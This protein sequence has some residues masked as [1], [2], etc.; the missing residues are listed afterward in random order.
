[1]PALSPVRLG[2]IE[3]RIEARVS[4]L[5]DQIL[6]N[7]PVDLVPLLSAPLPLLT[8]A[9]LLGVPSESWKDLYRWTNA[10]IGEDDPEFRQSPE[11]MGVIMGEF[12]AFSQDLF[13]R[14]RAEGLAALGGGIE[15]LPRVIGLKRAMGMMLTA[16]PVTA[17][18]GLELGFVN[19]VV[20][21]DVLGAARRWAADILAC[22]PMSV[23]ATKEAVLRGMDT[24][25]EESAQTIW[26]Y[27]AMVEML[28]SD[29][30][31]EGPKAFT[32]KRAPNWQG[33]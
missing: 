15:R 9:E 13:E 7:E 6:M 18:Q 31:A 14:R 3:A 23:R 32:E 19:E 10:F 4:Q 17:N 28:A 20:A 33:R 25:L 30:A 27:P 26:E 24:S 12:F 5:L 22:S 29:D 16:K 1:M 2:D 11:A 8:L 21:D